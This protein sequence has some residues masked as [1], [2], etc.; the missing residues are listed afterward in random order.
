MIRAGKNGSA[1]GAIALPI[2][3]ELGE[4]Y[5]SAPPI[6][7]DLFLGHNENL[8]APTIYYTFPQTCLIM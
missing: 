8:I 4:K 3:L 5:Y 6:F 1:G 7:S 2:F